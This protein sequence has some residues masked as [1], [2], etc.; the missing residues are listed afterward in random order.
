MLTV[1]S[2]SYNSNIGTNIYVTVVLSYFFVRGIMKYI[3]KYTQ[4]LCYKGCRCSVPLH[5]P[6]TML[7]TGMFC[8][9]TCIQPPGA[10]HRSTHTRDFCRN[11]NLRLSWMSLKAARDLNP[12]SE[13]IVNEQ[14]TIDKYSVNIIFVIA[15]LWPV[16]CRNLSTAQVT[17]S[18]LLIS[19]KNV[20]NWLGIFWS[21]N[22]YL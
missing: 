2:L 14:Q 17:E 13:N 6:T 15:Q 3:S 16:H 5:S 22:K 1:N 21:S 19:R 10:A 4:G 20:I 9:A 8:F 11:S 12:G 7:D 18:L